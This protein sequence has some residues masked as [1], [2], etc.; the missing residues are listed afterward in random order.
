MSYLLMMLCEPVA[1]AIPQ[2][3][4]LS[5]DSDV[6]DNFTV[7]M[8]NHKLPHSQLKR[9]IFRSGSCAG[10]RFGA[11]VERTVHDAQTVVS[12]PAIRPTFVAEI[13]V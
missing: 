13:L 9:G 5:K 4:Y 2:H 11:T 8:H 10:T 12:L 6:S 7:S 1:C 3:Q